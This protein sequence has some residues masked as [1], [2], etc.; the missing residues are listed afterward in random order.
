MIGLIA[1][2]GVVLL[3]MKTA[4]DP[5]TWRRF[6]LLQDAPE[7]E[8]AADFAEKRAEQAPPTSGGLAPDEFRAAADPES[9][10]AGQ[11]ADPEAADP[12]GTPDDSPAA[13]TPAAETPAD[14]SPADRE[15]LDRR[16]IEEGLAAVRDD[17][18][19]IRRAERPAY[20]AI[21]AE[22]R[23]ADRAGL[24]R[25]ARDDVG[26]KEL[27]EHPERHRGELIAV[28]G[29]MKKLLPFKAGENDHGLTRFYEAWVFTEDSHLDPIRV[30]CT[31]V[32]EGIPEGEFETLVPV[33][34][35]GRFF[36]IERYA[37]RHEKPHLAP[38]LLARRLEWIPPTPLETGHSSLSKYVLGF[39]LFVAAALGFALWRVSRG[40]KRFYHG[41][42]KRI[43]EAPR[44]HIEALEGIETTDPRTLLAELSAADARREAD[45]SRPPA[46]PAGLADE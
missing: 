43:I 44:E 42:L 8:T 17:T 34:L 20:Y 39:V 15:P 35:V 7:A 27:S 29:R 46:P 25:A 5:E 22:L 13:E 19:G 41:R 23:E 6:L 1:A 16:V 26:Y 4:A 12:G 37:A 33:R 32:S 40:D 45:R 36:K 2:L 24:R 28:E 3:A 18:F 14:E 9:A 21:L 38:L 11:P 30:V 10:E 31:E